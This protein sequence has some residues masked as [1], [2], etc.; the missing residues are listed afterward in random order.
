MCAGFFS[1]LT[2]PF[3]F[4]SL[5]CCHKNIT[6]VFFEI[7]TNNYS[8]GSKSLSFYFAFCNEKGSLC[9]SGLTKFPHCSTEPAV[10]LLF[11][12]YIW[13]RIHILDKTPI[14]Q[15]RLKWD[16]S[17]AWPIKR[18]NFIISTRIMIFCRRGHYVLPFLHCVCPPPAPPPFLLLQVKVH[19]CKER[20]NFLGGMGVGEVKG[21]LSLGTLTDT[22]W[23]IRDS[24]RA[25]LPFLQRRIPSSLHDVTWNLHILWVADVLV[26]CLT[27][28]KEKD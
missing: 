15:V 24:S 8:H 14:V 3:F 1:L 7:V 27:G 22:S 21:S 19:K 18:M 28:V 5:Y 26:V 2:L 9:T 17:V 10:H 20:V 23:A 11:W 13:R 25:G 16:V 12:F 4:R 6:Y